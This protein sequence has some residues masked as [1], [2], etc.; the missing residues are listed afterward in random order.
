MD[1]ESVSQNTP[2]VLAELEKDEIEATRRSGPWVPDHETSAL[3]DAAEGINADVWSSAL[4]DSTDNEEETTLPNNDGIQFRTMTHSAMGRDDIPLPKT[5]MFAA[6]QWE[7]WLED[8][9][10]E[11]TE[12]WC[13]PT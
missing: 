3:K 5:N 10:T 12:C 4:E 13:T 8:L 2:S 6:K 1:E 11:G 7:I 9:S